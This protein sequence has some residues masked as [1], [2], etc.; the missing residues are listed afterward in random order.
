MKKI[1]LPLLVLFILAL[2]CKKDSSVIATQKTK[3]ELLS[4]HTWQVKELI[5]QIGN[6][7]GRYVKGGTNTTGADYSKVRLVFNANGTGSFTDP[8]NQTYTLT[9]S[10]VS[11]DDTKMTVVVNYSTPA[12]LNY[13]FVAL[14]ENN[15]TYTIYY[16]DSGQNALATAHYI[17]L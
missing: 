7:Q 2:G 6:S 16:S 1:F 15:L 4:G 11:G 14:D 8:L 12:T 3:T 10:F 17:P 13:L 5:S 9:W